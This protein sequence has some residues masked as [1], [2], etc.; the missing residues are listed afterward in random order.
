[1]HIS[2]HLRVMLDRTAETKPRKGR[3]ESTKQEI[4]KGY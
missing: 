4:E 2:P 1:M 3:R